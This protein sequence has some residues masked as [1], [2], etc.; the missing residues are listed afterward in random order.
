MACE[1]MEWE[2]GIKGPYGMT[3]QLDPV[4]LDQ[5]RNKFAGLKR[6]STDVEV[7]PDKL[8]LKFK[9]AINKVGVRAFVWRYVNPILKGAVGEITPIGD[10]IQATSPPGAVQRTADT[11]PM[12]QEA[13]HPGVVQETAE[14][15]GVASSS[16]VPQEGEQRAVQRTAHAYIPLLAAKVCRQKQHCGSIIDT[17]F[18]KQFHEYQLDKALHVRRQRHSS[19]WLVQA[20]RRADHMSVVVK[21]I[22]QPAWELPDQILQE[23]V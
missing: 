3:G 22:L 17:L 4:V 1:H 14:T 18:H 11:Q 23:V 15:G 19:Y 13:V 12:P 9:Q 21:T 6:S 16:S 8:K 10:A 20:H 5:L 7:H 2:V